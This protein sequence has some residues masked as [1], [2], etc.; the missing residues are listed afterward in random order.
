MSGFTAVLRARAAAEPC[1]RKGRAAFG[2]PRKVK[3]TGGT[4]FEQTARTP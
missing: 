2:T 4:R 3:D 1:A